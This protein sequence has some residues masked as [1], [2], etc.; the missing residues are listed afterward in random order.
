[1]TYRQRRGRVRDPGAVHEQLHAPYYSY[2]IITYYCILEYSTLEYTIRLYYCVYEFTILLLYNIPYC[3]I[4][5]Y[6]FT[7]LTYY[8]TI[9]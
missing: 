8:T 1:M 6:E 9:L 3:Y 4:V 7:I 5:M 2:I